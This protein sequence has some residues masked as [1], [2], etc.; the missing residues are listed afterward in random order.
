MIPDPD[1]YVYFIEKHGPKE[2]EGDT[3]TFTYE[4]TLFLLLRHHLMIIQV[5]IWHFDGIPQQSHV[6]QL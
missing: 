3:D 4:Y 2:R 6:E 1:R 5:K